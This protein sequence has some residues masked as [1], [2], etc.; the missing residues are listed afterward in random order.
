MSIDKKIEMGRL[1]DVYGDLL[2][3]NQRDIASMYYDM[4]MSLKEISEQ[5]GDISRQ[6]VRD[7]IVRVDKILLDYETKLGLV[8]KSDY[9]DQSLSRM[10]N[11]DMSD[12]L[13][14]EMT[15]LRGLI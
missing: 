15:T 4:D 3:D 1:L 5:H 2:T 11:M 10:M 14:Q 13:R 7:T 8:A 9:L 6:A 12:E